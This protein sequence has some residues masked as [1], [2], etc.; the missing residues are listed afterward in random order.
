MS[1]DN[2]TSVTNQMIKRSLNASQLGQKSII[3][4]RL[5][6]NTCFIV[7]VGRI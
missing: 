7:H 4:N 3:K 6:E 5:I 2:F 1:Y